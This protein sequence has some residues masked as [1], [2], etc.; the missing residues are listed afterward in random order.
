MY[1]KRERWSRVGNN[2]SQVCGSGIA[3]AAA[4]VEDNEPELARDL[5]ERGRRLVEECRKFYEPDGCYPEGPAY[6][7]YGT[8]YHVLLLAAA[9]VL[10]REAEVP[11]VMRRSG[12]FILQ[13]TGSS[14][15]NFNFADAS[16]G[17]GGVTAA[18]AW[19]AGHFRDAGQA[20][21]IRARLAAGLGERKGF[22]E[23]RFDPLQ[24]LWL[25]AAPA[26]GTAR[27]PVAAVFEGQQPVALMRTGWDAGAAWFGGKGG[28]AAAS[29]GHMDAGSFV[30]DVFGTR[31]IH[32]LGPDDYNLPGYFGGKRWSYFRLNN[33]S[34][35]TLVIGGKCQDPKAAP[36]PVTAKRRDG[37][38]ST[39][40]FD[41]SPAY[42]GQAKQ[43]T[44][45]I[46]FD[47]KSGAVS[48]RDE[49]VAPGGDVRWAVVTDAEVEVAG[50]CAVLRKKDKTLTLRRVNAGGG[51]WESAEATPP[52]E[53]E[54]S[55][56]GFRM[57]RFTMPAVEKLT[58]E[59]VIQP[60]PA[61]S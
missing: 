58:I 50:A 53:V 30:Y 27:L 8:N 19:L 7:H 35:N 40:V 10:D 14:G 4:A 43:V 3:V 16:A 28:T 2:W 6:W 9:N 51:V 33:L 15:L 44:R 47:H 5:W 32:D 17:R 56:Q 57:V 13:V 37:A 38:V 21:E 20:A 59:V 60:G 12:D 34:H 54:K 49:V 36:C 61:G 26:A 25:P 46:K 42:R 55:N 18:Q 45:T 22:G 24:M 23:D 31:W 29:H 48:M 41:L 1:D 11:A 52:T 39:V